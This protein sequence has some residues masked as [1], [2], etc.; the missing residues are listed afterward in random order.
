M[1]AWD[2]YQELAQAHAIPAT[3]SDVC[4]TNQSNSNSNFSLLYRNSQGLPQSCQVFLRGVQTGTEYLVA[5]GPNTFTSKQIYNG[6]NV[7]NYYTFNL[8][9][10]RFKVEVFV[11][12]EHAMYANGYPLEIFGQC[13]GIQVVK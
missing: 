6:V 12:G 3:A 5:T 2:Y 9:T 7:E 4:F 8:I 11:N 13:T 10:G 1:T